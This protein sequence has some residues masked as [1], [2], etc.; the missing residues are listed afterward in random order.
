MRRREKKVGFPR[1]N[2]RAASV[3]F[4]DGERN[5]GLTDQN[6]KKRQGN[7]CCCSIAKS[8]LTLCNPLG[9]SMPGFPVLRYLPEFT[10]THVC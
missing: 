8:C 6:G 7:S 2:I 4:T 3:V 10:Q 5:E 9:L 1:G